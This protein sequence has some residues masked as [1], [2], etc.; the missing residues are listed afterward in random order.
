MVNDRGQSETTGNT[1]DN[2]IAAAVRLAAAHGTDASVRTITR[3]AGVTE[4]MLY[5]HFKNKDDLWRD[6]YTRIVTEMIDE[7]RALM[8]TDEPLSVRLREW[9]RLTYAYYDGNRDAFTY[10]LLMPHAFTEKLGTVCTRQGEMLRDLIVKGQRA[11]ECRAD[12]DPDL[13]VS[14]FGGLMLNIPRLINAGQ[15]P[16]PAMRHVDDVADAVHRVL[17]LNTP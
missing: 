4:A 14:H 1:R 11:D 6:I 12:L 17:G 2:L 15:L 16:G 5:R 10:V 9:I 8:H 13:A 3:E 7:K